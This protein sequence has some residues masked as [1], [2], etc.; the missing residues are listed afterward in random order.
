M[1]DTR[2]WAPRCDTPELSEGK[3]DLAPTRRRRRR[4]NDR[5]GTSLPLSQQ[6][7]STDSEDCSLSS[8]MSAESTSTVSRG[9]THTL[10]MR[11]SPFSIFLTFRPDLYLIF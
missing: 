2:M 3:K 5:K 4:I 11:S 6:F 8:N 1:S 7:Y 9:Q 10:Q